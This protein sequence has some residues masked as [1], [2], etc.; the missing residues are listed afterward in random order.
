[1]DAFDTLG[2]SEYLRYLELVNAE[3]ERQASATILGAAQSF[4][5]DA[6]NF[7]G[8]TE[9]VAE[10]QFLLAQAEF[11][12]RLAELQALSELYG[13]EIPG[14]ERLLELGREIADL[15]FGE[16]QKAQGAARDIAGALQDAANAISDAVS[17][18]LPRV[19]K[20]GVPW[21]QDPDRPFR[22]AAGGISSM[23]DELGRLVERLARAK[24]GIR[25]FL[26]A[27]ARGAMGGVTPEAGLAEARAQLEEMARLARGGDI[28]AFEGITGAAQN[29]LDLLRGQFASGPGF[30]SGLSFVQE[31]LSGLLDVTS[32]HSYNVIA[33]ERTWRRDTLDT[34][35]GGFGELEDTGK[36]SVAV[37][38]NVLAV[39]VEIKNGQTELNRR[40]TGL[41]ARKRIQK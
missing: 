7:L 9:E 32:V 12:L 24:E 19:P 6:L 1:L 5:I 37:Q 41:E 22:Q 27:L 28:T 13:I 10:L 26:D 11:Q 35:R 38:G 17:D 31:L 34:L 3:F 23:A 33:D 14:M 29:Y 15:T 39:L 40:L 36:Q 30:V 4:L 25:E 21:Y 20:T 8:R 2:P 16:W 18:T